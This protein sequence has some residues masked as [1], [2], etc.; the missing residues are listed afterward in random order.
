MYSQYVMSLTHWIARA[1]WYLVAVRYV[2]REYT[3]TASAKQ[4]ELRLCAPCFIF[5]T[6]KLPG[7][8]HQNEEDLERVCLHLPVLRSHRPCR[9]REQRHNLK[10]M[11]QDCERKLED[12]WVLVCMQ[13]ARRSS[14]STTCLVPDTP[15]W[16]NRIPTK[17]ES[18]S[19]LAR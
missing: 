17:F 12:I 8:R 16:L 2:D 13:I 14:W 6:V 7:L 15:S 5:A 11:F 3:H 18:P 1:T 10:R 19:W 4:Q 9:T